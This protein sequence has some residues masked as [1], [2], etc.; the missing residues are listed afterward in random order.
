MM[1]LTNPEAFEASFPSMDMEGRSTGT[2]EPYI[3]LPGASS[4]DMLFSL[5]L[6]T[7]CFEVMD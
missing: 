2:H 4:R 1:L 5:F 6:S 7:F 3:A